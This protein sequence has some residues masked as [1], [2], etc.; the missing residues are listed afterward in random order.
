[1]DTV[2]PV[3]EFFN[4]DRS[5]QNRTLL[6]ISMFHFVKLIVLVSVTDSVYLP[7]EQ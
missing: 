7:G 2:V 3:E 4:Q 1:M 6:N 5:F